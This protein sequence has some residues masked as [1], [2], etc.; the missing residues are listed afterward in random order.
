M[1]TLCDLWAV[2]DKGRGVVKLRGLW[3][4]E[5]G[6]VAAA[7]RDGGG[8]EGGRPVEPWLWVVG[9]GAVDCEPWGG[10]PRVVSRAWW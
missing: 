1:E 9:C 7:S 2:G 3:V 5:S 10:E 4:Q 8:S 6:A